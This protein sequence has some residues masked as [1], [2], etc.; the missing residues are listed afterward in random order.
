M[1]PLKLSMQAFGPYAG[2]QELDFS[3]LGSRRFFL[4]HG[5]TGAGKTSILDGM[6]FALYGRMSGSGRD[7]DKMRS[8]HA[9]PELPM[10]VSFEFTVGGS[11]YAVTRSPAQHLLVKGRERDTLPR[12]ELKALRGGAWEAI[13][14]GDTRVTAQVETILGFQ[15][16]QF[17]QV[18]VIPQGDFRKLLMSNSREREEILRVLLRV[19]GFKAIEDILKRRAK[20]LE[21]EM[22]TLT[23]ARDIILGEA[24]TPSPAA[25]AERMEQNAAAL[26]QMD[27]QIEETRKLLAASRQATQEARTVQVLLDERDASHRALEDHNGRAAD[28]KAMQEQLKRADAAAGLADAEASLARRQAELYAAQKALAHAEQ[29]AVEANK[30]RDMAASALAAKQG[31]EEER[32]TLAG[33]IIR[34]N[35]ALP[36]AQKLGALRQSAEAAEAAAQATQ[37]KRDAATKAVEA[38]AAVQQSL[39]AAIAAVEGEAETVAARRHEWEQLA[40][41]AGKRKL[42]DALT[43]ELDTILENSKDRALVLMEAQ[44]RLEEHTATHRTARRAWEGAQAALLANEMKEGM[45]CPVCG[46]THHPQ[47]AAMPEGT[48]TQAEQ[49]GME[50][51]ETELKADVEAKAGQLNEQQLVLAQRETKVA[52]CRQELGERAVMTAEQVQAEAAGAEKLWQSAAASAETLARLKAD[53]KAEVYNRITIDEAAVLAAAAHEQA[54]AASLKAAAELHALEEQVPEKMRDSA[55]IEQYL[56]RKQKQAQDLE[57]A[58]ESARKAANQAVEKATGAAAA[59]LAAR[60]AASSALAVFTQEESGFAARLGDCGFAAMESYSAAKQ[61]IGIREQWK[62]DVESYKNAAAAAADRLARAEK[63]AE[64]APPDLPALELLEQQANDEMER[65]LREH[66]GLAA[67]L[68]SERGWAQKLAAQETKITA[69]KADYAVMGELAHVANGSNPMGLTLQRFVLGALFDDVA[70]AAT[71]RL[72]I[73]SRGRYMLQR[74]M[75]RARQNAAGGLELEVF[76]E[77]TG[78]S[79]PVATLSGG[80]SFLASLALAL[81]LADVVQSHAGGV[82]LETI[83]VDEGFGTLDQ[84]SL[85]E[86]L[87][88][89]LEL[90]SAGRLVGIISH[91]PELRERID[92]RL[93]V[94][95]AEKGSVARFVIG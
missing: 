68:Q 36:A 27:G 73:M 92:A 8:D 1:R 17:R 29:A 65:V 79:R 85:E 50:D 43:L 72:R 23:D 12:A 20:A 33:Q 32:K 38:N 64:V 10:E 91:V 4:I 86:A 69:L 30:E 45:P 19:D 77:Y 34:L 70:R 82:Y 13:A 67:R 76:D 46:S 55:V 95:P 59:L 5:P 14:S 56:A 75:E 87:K 24:E 42:L 54:W 41:L 26:A 15:Y 53:L 94:L 61:P 66:A 31:R 57:Q 47:R 18:V 71:H 52:A 21:D 11:Q 80:E 49:D 6:C 22:R 9:A 16:E 90:Q 74:T 37:D 81:G 58:L 60:A 89:L 25:L 2:R 48:P 84:E 93:E 40:A 35:D 78:V 7:G 62:H 51:R 63:A 44:A 88:A 28:M 3:L 39:H 83:F